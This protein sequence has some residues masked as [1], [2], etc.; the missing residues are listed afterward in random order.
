MNW[1]DRTLVIVAT[2]VAFVV[3]I[4][5]APELHEAVRALWR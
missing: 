5:I 3:G 1:R 4:I 2:L